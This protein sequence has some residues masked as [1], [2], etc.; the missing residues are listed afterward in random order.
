MKANLKVTLVSL[1]L[2][3]AKPALRDVEPFKT[4]LSGDLQA[5]AKPSQD[6]IP[7]RARE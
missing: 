3:T 1:A 4:V 7:T 5:M 2:V 6:A